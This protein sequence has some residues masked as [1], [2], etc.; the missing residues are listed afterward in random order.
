M[1]GASDDQFFE[2]AGEIKKRYQLYICCNEWGLHYFVYSILEDRNDYIIILGPY[3]DKIPNLHQLNKDYNLSVN[4]GALLNEYIGKI[5]VLTPEQMASIGNILQQFPNMMEKETNPHYLYQEKKEQ[6]K[7]RKRETVLEDEET[8]LVNLRYEIENEFMYAVEQGDKKLAKNLIGA[9]NPLFSFSERFPDQPL[10][11]V[12]NLSI[13]R[14]T[15]LRI[16]AKNS[17]VPP[18]LLHR[19]SE[20]YV[21]EIEKASQLEVLYEMND[22]M[23]DEYCDLVLSHSLRSYSIMAKTVIEHLMSHFDQPLNKEELAK[24][25]HTHPSHLSRKFKQETKMTISAYQ[26]MLRINRAKQLLKKD[27]SIEEIAWS[28]GYNDP[29]YF[30]R[31]FKKETGLSPTEYR[32]GSNLQ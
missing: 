30:A 20:K 18:I 23:I 4:E 21:F 25:C 3:F 10:R 9:H 11:R 6:D 24:K 26:Q 28:V 8:E 16:A 27:L 14:N 32:N 29:S 15:V 17:K 31:V 13:V 2:L 1:P 12:K 7:R 19:L 5:H 22:R